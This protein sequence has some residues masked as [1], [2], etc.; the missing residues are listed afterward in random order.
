MTSAAPDFCKIS[1]MT[2]Y[3][4][5]TD[6]N[7]DPAEKEIAGRYIRTLYM[8]RLPERTG[9]ALVAAIA[10]PQLRMAAQS[11]RSQVR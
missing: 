8:N 9:T 10:A 11:L 1:D 4:E 3:I 2:D 6:P 5:A 7:A